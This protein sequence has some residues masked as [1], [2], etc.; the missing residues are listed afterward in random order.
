MQRGLS[1]MNLKKYYIT[2]FLMT[3]ILSPSIIS[4]GTLGA[5]F[6]VISIMLLIMSW[7]EYLERTT[8][9]EQGFKVF[10]PIFLVFSYNMC[11]WIIIFMLS[12]YSFYSDYFNI[13]VLLTI[14]YLVINF[15]FEFSVNFSPF[16]F[17]N[18][19][20]T[21]IIVL[22]IIISCVIRKKKIIF[23]K[24]SMVYLVVFICLSGIATFQHNERNIKILMYDYQAER[25]QGDI[26]LSKYHPFMWDDKKND[27]LKALNEPPAIS[28]SENY[29]KLD[30]ATAL[31]PVY[32]AIAQ[33]LYEGLN[34]TT[35]AKYVKYSKTDKAYENLMNG[36]IDIFFGAQPSTQQ[37]ETAREKGVE[38]VLTPIGKEA[39]VFFVHKDNPVDSLTLEQIQDIYQK[40]I[41]NWKEV[42]GSWERIMPFQRPENSGSQ[43]IMLAKV[44]QEKQLTEPVMEEYIEGMSGVIT[45]VAE[46]RNYSSAIGYSFRYFATGM[47]PND[48]IKLLGVDEVLPTVENIR[49]DTYMFTVDVYA[50]TI[51]SSANENTEQLIQWLLSEQGQN[52]IEDCGYVKQ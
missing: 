5:G 47:N 42:G 15:A 9:P 25:V 10:L 8:L 27:E 45:Q 34:G 23:D 28:F 12:G 32:S 14:P 2:T 22:V 16:P 19:G 20:I 29:P 4:L 33:E 48:S 1:F 41:T 21:L 3:L 38:F 13:F 26:D 11:A 40:N 36:E 44:M 37:I 7:V 51:N 31:Y 52:F 49:N 35:V 43:T 18:M 17:I 24:I 50:V 39:F 30:G 46:Y 6:I